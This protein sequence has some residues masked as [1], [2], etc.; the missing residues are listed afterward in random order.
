M[1]AKPW[2]DLIPEEDAASFRSTGGAGDRPLSVG[3]R[4]AVLVVD[5]TYEFV[6]SAYPTGWSPT[7]WPAVAAVARLLAAARGGDVPVFF[8]KAHPDPRHVETP[9]ERGRWRRRAQDLA[10]PAS[11]PGDV[12]VEELQPLDGE[13]VVHKGS[14]PSAFFGTPLTSLLVHHQVDT[15]IVAGMTTSGCVRATVVDAFSANFHVVVPAECVADRSQISHKVNL[16][17]IHMKYA[18]VV[19]LQ[20]TL[21]YLATVTASG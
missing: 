14:K 5:M 4:P 1:T 9:A 7:G 15:V 21:A 11:P 10:D 12:I 16:F 8:T 20:E 2:H 3:R 13:V 18:D 17:D 19:S 6:D